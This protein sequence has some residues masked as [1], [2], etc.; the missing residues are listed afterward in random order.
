MI[1]IEE[2][3]QRI[4]SSSSIEFVE[5]CCALLL[6]I[7][8]R[9]G[10]SLEGLSWNFNINE[11][12][13]GVDGRFVEANK[14]VPRFIPSPKVAYQFKSGDGAG[15]PEK[16]AN[17][18]ILKKKNVKKVLDEGG[19]FVFFA[20]RDRA[21]DMEQKICSELNK[22]GYPISEER[23]VYIGGGCIAGLLQKQYPG[24]LYRYLRIRKYCESFNSWSK[25]ESLTNPF[26]RDLDEVQQKLQEFEYLVR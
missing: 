20:G 19:S 22:K 3:K 4:R 21:E 8:E 25:K 5:L 9:H 1:G 14:T 18:D 23:I 13:G 16:I 11:K 12:D 6:S 24:L 7:G 26:V 10:V 2:I 15:S 17:E